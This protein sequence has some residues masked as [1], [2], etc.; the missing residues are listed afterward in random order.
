MIRFG[1]LLGA[2]L[3]LPATMSAHAQE[4]PYS[5][6][7]S[8][9]SGMSWLNR[10]DFTKI[11][12]TPSFKFGYQRMG[13]SLNVPIPFRF[14]VGGED[15]YEGDSVQLKLPDVNLW[16]GEA[17]IDV[18]MTPAISIYA[19][20]AGNLLQNLFLSLSGRSTNGIDAA[21]WRTHSLSWMEI[22]GGMRYSF[23]SAF[24]VV[25][26]VRW[27]HFDLTIKD[28]KVLTKVNLG[29]YR[30]LSL[31]TSDVLSELWVP[32]I[33]S[34][35]R[36]K[37]LRVLLIGTPFA[38]VVLRVRTRLRADILPSYNFLGESS[39]TMKSS[40]A[41]VEARLEYK[42]QLAKKTKLSLWGKGGWLYARGGGRLESGYSTTHSGLTVGIG[43][44]R[45]LKFSRFT[46]GGG[47]A[48][49]TTF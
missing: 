12:Y 5:F 49:N 33:G 38:P 4:G 28:P 30:N 20:G 17:G 47:M 13:M 34:E 24:A 23:R 19:N 44:D 6:P 10:I 32:Y 45:R 42:I 39:I 21:T 26:G 2:L 11:K 14:S 35:L 22:E 46:L 37:D 25:S 48:L 9:F 41:F 43:N 3:V 27:D 7:A 1:V 16:I 15:T 31:L 29:A 18:R 36:Y 8:A 40:A